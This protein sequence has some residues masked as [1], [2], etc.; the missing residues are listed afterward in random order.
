MFLSL[1]REVNTLI[2]SFLNRQEYKQSVP[3]RTLLYD[4]SYLSLDECA[5]NESKIV[6]QLSDEEFALL[7]YRSCELGNVK[8]VQN[9][10]K[11]GRIKEP[12]PRDY[13][14]SVQLVTYRDSPKEKLRVDK[15]TEKI[16]SDGRFFYSTHCQSY[17][18]RNTLLDCER[19][20]YYAA[21][22]RQIEVLKL[23][24]NSSK[25]DLSHVYV[26]R[27]I[28]LL[29]RSK[30][31]RND[32][33]EFVKFLLKDPRVRSLS[34]PIKVYLVENMIHY[35]LLQMTKLILNDSLF[36]E[37]SRIALH[38]SARYGHLEII[39]WL[40]DESRIKLETSDS[41]M[42]SLAASRGQLETVKFLLSLDVMDPSFDN[43]DS[44]INAAREGNIEIVKLL[45]NDPRVD[46]SVNNSSALQTA[47]RYEHLEVAELLIQDP[48]I[49][50][51]A[52]NEILLSIACSESLSLVK[53][54]LEDPRIKLTQSDSKIIRAAV[55]NT[56][57]EI[58][59]LLLSREELD[60]SF[61][62]NEAIEVAIKNNNVEAV[63][64]L[65]EDPRVDPSINP[66]NLY[67]AITYDSNYYRNTRNCAQCKIVTLL[68]GDSRVHDA[69]LPF[70]FPPFPPFLAY[71]KEMFRREKLSKFRDEIN[72]EGKLIDRVFCLAVFN[73]KL[74]II[75]LLLENTFCN[76]RADPSW[77]NNLA[78]RIATYRDFLQVTELLLKD[79]RVNP[80]VNNNEAIY[81]ALELN[82]RV[83]E[84]LLANSRVRL[85]STER[86][87][88]LA[89][90][91]ER[92]EKEKLMY[93]EKL[94]YDENLDESSRRSSRR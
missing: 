31:P 94:I 10:L 60:P 17:F 42:I 88:I 29:D 75:K 64:L 47:L 40:I 18:D 16:N 15:V 8:L 26:E 66:D 13:K 58:L 38:N 20:F 67:R 74:D 51:R 45:L 89:T 82:N 19:V 6:V 27:I 54:T 93:E 87:G 5:K 62:N 85:T 57:T 52:D 90:I 59:K 1:P 4:L 9:L 78:I 56:N 39:K 7:F 28:Y 92:K 3:C 30:S 44:I 23:L 11:D 25:F 72:F 41:V 35:G 37:Y 81:L 91:A 86:E 24:L 48:R 14:L 80:S 33:F 55:F 2:F 53:K 12:K 22:N 43:N 49:D 65:L 79:E 63:R 83:V 77:K 46:P 70:I 73:S 76:Q 71:N 32:H 21:M 68:L 34:D 84:L 50:F 36:K 61:N 69:N